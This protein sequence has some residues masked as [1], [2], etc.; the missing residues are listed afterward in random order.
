MP[1]VQPLL[2]TTSIDYEVLQEYTE[3]IPVRHARYAFAYDVRSDFVEFS[4]DLF[5]SNTNLY[6][7]DLSLNNTLNSFFA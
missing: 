1:S 7:L 4:H 6:S 3:E 5:L 2:G